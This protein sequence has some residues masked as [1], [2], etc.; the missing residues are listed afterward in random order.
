M[1]TVYTEPCTTLAYLEPWHIQNPRHIQNTAKHLSWNT[2]LK[3]LC[4]LEIKAYSESRRISKMQHFILEPSVTIANLDA[5]YIQNFPLF[6]TRVC[7]LL[8]HQLFLELLTYYC[9]HCSFLKNGLPIL[10]FKRI[11]YQHSFL[12]NELPLLFLKEWATP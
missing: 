9:I 4:N 1:N 7:Q 5:Q 11:G 10:F 2:S 12:K 8:M 3:I 6:T